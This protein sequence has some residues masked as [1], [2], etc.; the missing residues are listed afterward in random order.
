MLDQDAVKYTQQLIESAATA[1]LSRLIRNFPEGTSL[2]QDAVAN[3]EITYGSL[4]AKEQET[5][6]QLTNDL[7]AF[8]E[9]TDPTPFEIAYLEYAANFA[10]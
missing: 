4:R 9:A 7:R 8:A 1:D 2:I 10:G 5:L 3:I 6:R